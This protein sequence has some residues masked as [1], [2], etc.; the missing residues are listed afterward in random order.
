MKKTHFLLYACSALLGAAACHTCQQTE[1]IARLGAQEAR[2]GGPV[3]PAPRGFRPQWTPPG[4]ATSPVVDGVDSLTPE[5]RVNIAVYEKTNRGVVNITTQTFQTNFFFMAETPSQGTGSGSVLDQQGH[6]LTNLH[7]VNGAEQIMVTLFNG[8]SHEAQ[9]V[10]LDPPSDT[11]VL[12]ID[13]PPEQLFPLIVARSY[14]LRVGQKVYAIGNPFGLERTMTVGIISSLNRSLRSQSGRMMESIIQ[15]DAALNRGNSGGPLLDSSGRLIGMN[16]AIASSTGENTGVGFAIPASTLGRVVPELI[17]HGKV[18]RADI[19][20]TRIH[21]TD[22]GVVVVATRP[23]GPAD[24]AGLRG[25]RVVRDQFRQGPFLY[26]RSRVDRSHADMIVTV[27]GVKVR[28]KD[29]LL[30]VI[31]RKKPGDLVRLAVI[32]D[33]RQQLIAVRLGEN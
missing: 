9:I 20:I 7:V 10:G 17:A 18:I 28:T 3:S 8:E 1:F 22:Q 6:I 13:A 4:S 29:E 26:E 32:R 21:E 5:E 2:P 23:G 19:G 16:T 14:R 25:Y 24:A 30:G 12:K 11:A 33:G 27:D 15:L 31:E